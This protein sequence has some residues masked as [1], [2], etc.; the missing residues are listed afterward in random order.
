MTLE[1]TNLYSKHMHSN[2]KSQIFTKFVGRLE[3]KPQERSSLL[4]GKFTSNHT[5]SGFSVQLEPDPD[6]AESVVTQITKLEEDKHYRLILQIT[7]D[8]TKTIYAEVWQI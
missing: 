2:K 7:N 8:S 1:R 6:P 3:V 5:P 4:L